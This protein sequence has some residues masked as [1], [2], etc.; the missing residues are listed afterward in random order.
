MR[1]LTARQLTPGEWKFTCPLHDP[2]AEWIFASSPNN[3]I[4]VLKEHLDADHQGVKSRIKIMGD[5]DIH[6]T[7]TATQTVETGEYL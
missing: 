4:T 6:A 2:P 7:Y 3:A 5:Y 1:T